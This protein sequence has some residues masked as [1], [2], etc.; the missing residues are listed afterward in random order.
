[1]KKYIKVTI[2]IALI[3]IAFWLVGWEIWLA[4]SYVMGK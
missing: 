2:Q 3:G 4:I 1:M